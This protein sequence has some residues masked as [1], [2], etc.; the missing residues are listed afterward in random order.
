MSAAVPTANGH[1]TAVSSLTE[2]R[3]RKR[4]IASD[5]EQLFSLFASLAREAGRE[6]LI[7]EFE[8]RA[9]GA[10]RPVL[11]RPRVANAEADRFH[12][13]GCR[14]VR[15]GK[16]EEA[17]AMFRR[18][19][20]L[21]P[22]FADAH[23]NLGVAM[24]QLRRL[25]EAEA[26]FRVAIR[27]DP[28][29]VTM[30]VNLATCLLQQGRHGECETWARQAI[31]LDPGIAEA[32]RLLGCSLEA[33]N[34]LDP[35]EAALAEAVR[36]DPRLVEAQHRYGVVL[37]RREKPKEAETALREAVKLRPDHAGAWAA[38]ANVLG[39]QDRHAEAAECAKEAV[40]FEPESADLHN[41]YGVALAGCEK[42]PQAEQE[43]R[44]A[45]KLNP[46]L[47]SAHSN[48]GNTLR[49]LGRLED[50]EASLRE[51][52]KLRPNYPEAHNNLGIV[53]VQMGRDEEALKEYDE[54]IRIAPDYPEARM[55]RSFAYLGNG[56]FTRGWT[57]YEWRWKVKPF[58]TNKDPGPRWAGSPIEGKTLLVL[59]EQGLGDSLQFVRYLKLARERC[60]RIIFDAPVPLVGLM[61][62]CPGIDMV[63][64][65]GKGGPTFDVCIP[66]LSLPQ[67]FGIPPDAATAAIPYFRV[68]S[69]RVKYWQ[70]ETANVPGLK[71]GIV[72]QGSKSHKGDRLRSVPLT[73]FAPLAA[74]PGVSLCSIQ[75]GTG[76]E[77]LTEGAAA[78]MGVIDYGG[79]LGP[80]MSDVAALMMS[81]DLIVAID[82][83]IVHLAGAL[84]RPV[85]AA[86]PSAAD[87]RWLRSGE[88]TNWY[89]TVRLFRQPVRGDWDSVFG[90]IAVSLAAASKAKAE[91]QWD[92][93]PLKTAE[94]AGAAP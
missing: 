16:I 56:D 14:L 79:R 42:Y 17:E 5:D 63:V 33:R 12:K 87:W 78:G 43:Y 39:N 48:L 62:T 7:A 50:A 94:A 38:L 60:G 85:W 10:S 40:K 86:V 24:G 15:E 76:S 25:P 74:I 45:L 90:K 88:T 2:S 19:I 23:G 57:E 91:G 82:T 65:R 77:Q 59:S 11:A 69:E 13:D 92:A 72:W 83:A 21:D 41:G 66:L 51:A 58:K 61:E 34:K 54:A 30:Y 3:K 49:S 80:D 27:L 22:G 93:D 64:P 89:P 8:R 28:S 6:D 26:A 29:V 18:A 84:G 46:K 81:L 53:L 70:E 52:L 31:Q 71:V 9:A 36:L 35:A 4:H 47:W 37:S 44:E 67:F 55:N 73:R 20:R 1:A 68:N 32:H 75:K